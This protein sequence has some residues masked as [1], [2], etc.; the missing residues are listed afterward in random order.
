LGDL[1][2]KGEISQVRR[3]KLSQVRERAGGGRRNGQGGLCLKALRSNLLEGTVKKKKVN[4]ENHSKGKKGGYE[5]AGKSQ[6]E[7][8][9]RDEQQPG[10]KWVKTF[11]SEARKN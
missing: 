9:K 4:A 3:G 5:E 7:R 10:K 8:G 11:S 1:R 2:E 6:M